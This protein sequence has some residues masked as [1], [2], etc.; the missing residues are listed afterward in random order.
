MP[1]SKNIEALYSMEKHLYSFRDWPEVFT[2]TYFPKHIEQCRQEL[3]EFY[4][5]YCSMISINKYFSPSNLAYQHGNWHMS[6][7]LNKM[8]NRITEQKIKELTNA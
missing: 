6:N 3:K 5:F 8:V 1:K 7:K 4:N 2:E